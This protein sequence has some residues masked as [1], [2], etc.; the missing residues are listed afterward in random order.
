MTARKNNT[1]KLALLA[2]LTAT[3][4]VLQL[5][6]S[7]IRFGTFSISLVL[8][9]IVIGTAV[10]GIGGGAWLGLVFGL[11]VLLSGDAAF[12]LSINPAGTVVTVLIKGILAGVASGAV[13]KLLRSRNRTLAVICAAIVCPVVNTGIFLLGCRLFF[14]ESIRQMAGG[15]DVL[16]YMLTTLVGGNFIFELGVN[17]V[18]SPVIVRL[19][20]MGIIKEQESQ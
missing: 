20:G 2:I 8:I 10:G 18:L 3:V 5:L 9:P 17:A 14:F 12:F 15:A 1:K 19:L 16:I 4:I 13:F 6:G 7:F 11:T